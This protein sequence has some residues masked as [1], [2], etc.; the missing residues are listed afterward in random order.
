LCIR[1]LGCQ[2]ER[3]DKPL[4]ILILDDIVG[5][6]SPAVAE[7]F[8]LPLLRRINSNFPDCVHI[9]HND[10]PN[11]DVFPGLSTVGIDVFNFSHQISLGQ[12]RKLLGPEIVL[13][14]NIAPLDILVRGSIEDVQKA[15]HEIIQGMDEYG[16]ILI[17]PGGGVSPD[18][19]IENL[20]AAAEI[21]S[22]FQ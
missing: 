19:P 3:M 5:M 6:L 15:T 16:P 9:F 1:W 12:A 8:A 18:T 2:L 13:M 11:K 7:K 21:V 17:S 14:G 22:T 4:G 20:K 10:T